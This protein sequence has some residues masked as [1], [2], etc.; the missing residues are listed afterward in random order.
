MVNFKWSLSVLTML[1]LPVSGCV[2]ALEQTSEYACEADSDC[3]SGSTCFAERGHTLSDG[4]GICGVKGIA[5]V[6][7][8]DCTRPMLCRRPAAPGYGDTRSVLGKCELPPAGVA[9]FADE[10]CLTGMDCVPQ[11]GQC[12]EKMR[13][14]HQDSDCVEGQFCVL[15]GSYCKSIYCTA[16]EEC[17]PY[18]CDRLRD[19]GS[20]YCSSSSSCAAGAVCRDLKCQAE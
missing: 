6:D 11:T 20:G 13:G 12:T 16:D 15:G 5:C 2:R 9:C 7:S 3:P 8:E 17:F 4:D 1:S 18:R 19:C 14:C 10:D